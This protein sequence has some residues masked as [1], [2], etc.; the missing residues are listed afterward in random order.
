M[1][2]ISVPEL[3]MND[4]NSIPALGFGTYKLNGSAGVETMVNAIRSGYRLLDSA[5]KYENEGAVGE[6]IRRSGVAREELLVTSKVPGLRHRYN[7]ALY[8]VEESLYRA[9]L[10]YYDFILSIGP[11]PVRICTWKHGRRLLK[12]VNG[13]WSVQSA[14]VISCLSICKGLWMN[15]GGPGSESGRTVSLFIQQEQRD[16]HEQHGIITQSWSPLGRDSSAMQEAVIKAIGD[17]YE[18]ALRR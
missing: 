18:K 1:S 6:A 3:K 4:G 14:A 9:G 8:S 16:W 13:G 2:V 7:E 15:R 17:K 10:E 12:P 11:I 5:F